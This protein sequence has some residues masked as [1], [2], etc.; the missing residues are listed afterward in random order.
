[1]G[2]RCRIESTLGFPQLARLE[3]LSLAHNRFVPLRIA[4]SVDDGKTNTLLLPASLTRVDGL[5]RPIKF[6][7]LRYLDMRGNEIDG[8]GGLASL[9]R[10]KVA[11]TVDFPVPLLSH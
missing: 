9:Q 5:L 11:L 4:P 3:E 2:C 7:R 8:L 10:F 1:M 6:P